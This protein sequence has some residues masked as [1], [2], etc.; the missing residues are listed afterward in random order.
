MIGELRTGVHNNIIDCVFELKKLIHIE[1]EA[2]R[3]KNCTMH[4]VHSVVFKD[5]GNNCL[6]VTEKR[7]FLPV[8]YHK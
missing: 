5:E 7:S 1:R 8:K 2:L 3:A 4:I 6:E